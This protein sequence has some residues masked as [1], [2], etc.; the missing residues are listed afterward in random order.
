MGKRTSA[1]R[2]LTSGTVE[3]LARLASACRKVL[4]FLLVPFVLASLS[5][6]AHAFP[7]GPRYTVSTWGIPEGAPSDVRALAMTS[8]GFMWLGT[9][10]GLYRFDGVHFTR[11]E[12]PLYAAVPSGIWA[13]AA[14]DNNGLWVGARSRVTL[15]EDAV[16]KQEEYLPAAVGPIR[17]L[18]MAPSNQPV[19]V[20]SNDVLM[21]SADA[22]KSILPP[23]DAYRTTY[24]SAFRAQDDALWIASSEGVLRRDPRSGAIAKLSTQAEAGHFTQSADGTVWYQDIQ[25]GLTAFTSAKAIQRWPGEKGHL[26]MSVGTDVLVMA[27]E[28]GLRVANANP[29]Q[30]SDANGAFPRQAIVEQDDALGKLAARDLLADRE[31][32][33]W[34]ATYDGLARLR[35]NRLIE[36]WVGQSGGLAATGNGLMVL[37]YETGL[38]QGGAALTNMPLP[39]K[40]GTCIYEDAAGTV[41]IGGRNQRALVQIKD[42]RI[43]TLALPEMPDGAYVAAIGVDQAGGVWFTAHP[44]GTYRWH[45]GQWMDR[46]GFTEMPRYG[47]SYALGED[48]RFWAGYANNKIFAIAG[49]TLKEYGPE[50]GVGVG[51]VYSVAARADL[52]AI[53]GEEGVDLL[54]ADKFVRLRASVGLMGVS[55]LLLTRGG[56]LWINQSNGLVRIP[57]AELAAFMRTPSIAVRAEMF[58]FRDG[59]KGSATPTPPLPNAA[60]ADDGTLWFSA[61]NIVRINPENIPRN[62]V[63]PRAKILTVSTDRTTVRAGSEISLPQGTRAFSVEFAAPSMTDPAKV[64]YRY[65]LEGVDEG[66]RE[67]HGVNQASYSNL[68]SGNHVFS[69]IAANED[70]VW[71]KVGAQSRIEVPLFFHEHLWF[72]ALVVVI[73]G[74]VLWFAF[75]LRSLQV[76]A[77]VRDRLRERSKE[78]ERIARD[79]H[80]TMLQGIQGLMLHLQVLSDGLTQGDPNRRSLE[81]ALDNADTLVREGRER[82]GDLRGL[83]G[84]IDL[85]DYFREILESLRGGSRVRFTMSEEGERVEMTPE[86]TDEIKKIVSEALVNALRHSQATNIKV[87]VVYDARAFSVQVIDD[88]IGIPDEV[89]SAG[90]RDGHWGLAG[91]RERAQ[92]VGGSVEACNVTDGSG[93]VVTVRVPA[94]SAYARRRPGMSVLLAICDRLGWRVR[95]ASLLGRRTA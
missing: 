34:A 72:K 94:A 8:D 21:R 81:T 95:A 19:A 54:L 87:A 30:A 74:L 46:G 36:P 23:V 11:M 18:L 80:D 10:T 84:A 45:D 67:V 70:G 16:L 37:S 79:L 77:Q 76:A 6:A 2:L 38:S 43:T 17:Q 22:W 20:T 25:Y 64:R 1:Y 42:G 40:E 57:K 47:R 53:G 78:R 41:W 63:A 82:L 86:A 29:N 88:G 24:Y 12:P 13:L 83:E 90:G 69:V 93:A 49:H 15:L 66:W 71:D 39:I 27:G 91:M 89:L 85:S 68:P 48:G 75:W 28:V 50:Q 3:E 62:V 51:T 14:T 92:R 60:E 32:N 56:D 7:V 61:A 5:S 9:G 4:A 35:T 31:G 44:G 52:V 59:L 65:R 26:V 33:Y 58:D 73:G 55:S